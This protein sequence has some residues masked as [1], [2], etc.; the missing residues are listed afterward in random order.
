[1]P[2]PSTDRA[3]FPKAV[4]TGWIVA[5]VLALVA[6]FFAL[7]TSGLRT[8]NALHRHDADL[9]HTES[10]GLAQQLEAERILYSASIDHLQKSA[11][12]SAP[13]IVRLAAPSPDDSDALAFVVWNAG[14]QD[15]VLFVEKLP[16]LASDQIYRLWITD[17]SH[18]APSEGCVVDDGTTRAA[19]IAI[20][21]TRRIAS[22]TS[23]VLTRERKSDSPQ[24]DHGAVVA[25]G[26]L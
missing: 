17:A 1:M 22:P 7:Q 16:A 26:T 9:A 11:T 21:P 10:Q 8:Q 20:R 25:R 15:G 2:S 18:S 19:R 13:Q 6:A 12:A 24:P 14:A 4:W 3:P 5:A 23:F